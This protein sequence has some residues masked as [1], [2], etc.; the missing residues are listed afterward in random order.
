LSLVTEE[1]ESEQERIN[2]GNEIKD[3]STRLFK[4]HGHYKLSSEADVKKLNEEIIGNF[5]KRAS[6]AK[7]TIIKLV[8]IHIRCLKYI[9]E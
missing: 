1:D 2:V 5:R 3:V 6:H 8:E 4:E 7:N 9:I